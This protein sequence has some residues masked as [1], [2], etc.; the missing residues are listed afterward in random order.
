[1]HAASLEAVSQSTG[2]FS[3]D[4]STGKFTLSTDGWRNSI[5]DDHRWQAAVKSSSRRHRGWRCTAGGVFVAAECVV[6]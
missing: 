6:W 4:A 1:M 5:H 2:E 3:P